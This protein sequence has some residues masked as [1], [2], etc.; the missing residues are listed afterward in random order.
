MRDQKPFQVIEHALSQR[1]SQHVLPGTGAEWYRIYSK[2]SHFFLFLSL[3]LH[4]HLS[5]LSHAYWCG[6][7]PHGLKFPPITI[8][9]MTPVSTVCFQLHEKGL[10]SSILLLSTDMPS[11]RLQPSPMS[12][13]S[14][15]PSLKSAPRLPPPS[16]VSLQ[17]AEGT[18]FAPAACCH[19]HRTTAS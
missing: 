18:L 19:Q 12:K 17:T 7:F 9:P 16:R 15:S 5:L 14:N 1:S 11:L 13:R 4:P 8:P 2:T 10:T 6:I 3:L